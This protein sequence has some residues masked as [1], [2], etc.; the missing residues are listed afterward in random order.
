MSASREKKTRQEPSGL[1]LTPKQ[2]KQQKEAEQARLRRIGYTVLGIV[3]A[4]LTVALLVW[5]SNFFQSRATAVTVNGEKFTAAD[6]QYYYNSAFQQ[7]YSTAASLAAYGATGGFDFMAAPKDQIYDEESGKTWH[8]YFMDTAIDNL[9]RDAAL[10]AEAT[11]Y[12]HSLTA[13]GQ[14][15]IDSALDSI[16]SSWLGSGYG[17]RDAFIRAQFGT[18]MSYDKFV[19][20]VQRAALAADYSQAHYDSFTYDDATLDAYYLENADS[21]DTFTITQFVFQAKPETKTDAEGNTV[22]MTEEETAAALEQAKAEA[23]A[24]AD[25]VQAALLA[26][27][28]PNSLVTEY[29]PYL[30]SVSESS[31]G[32]GVNTSYS[33]WAFDPQ[34]KDGDV[35]VAE[36]DGETFYNYYVARFEGRAL[37][38][39]PTADVRHILVAAE[40]TEPTE[41][42]YAAAQAKAQELLN[43]WKA[44]EATEDSF[45]ALATEN[46][47]DTGSQATGGLYEHISNADSLADEFKSWATDPARQAGDTGIVR[48]TQSSVKGYHV[49]YFVGWDDPKW[50]VTAE[51]TLRNDDYTKWQETLL[52]GYT[53]E[54]GSGLKYVA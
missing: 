39:T 40:G 19:S 35:T 36:Y 47:A 28:D 54:R 29:E 51:T 48:N 44:G 41:E 2:I 6:V 52:E 42:Q 1:G 23:K 21:L 46:T 7:A 53:A 11:A 4:L 49:M 50:M 22:E 18:T 32:S 10:A 43:Q 15:S 30:S 3:L 37:D 34:R 5:N 9:K 13:E 38:E 25:A 17:S 24:K 45:A 8:D 33:E 27:E 20:I 31:T 26:G 14:S 12:G 16:E